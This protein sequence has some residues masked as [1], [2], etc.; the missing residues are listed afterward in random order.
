MIRDSIGQNI[1]LPDTTALR[2]L[3]RDPAFD[4]HVDPEGESL[5]SK[6]IHW[7][8]KVFEVKHGTFAENFWMEYFWYIMFAVIVAIILYLIFKNEIRG[9]FYRKSKL[10]GGTM[11][12]LDDDINAYDFDK[13][14][15]EAEANRNYRYAIRLFYLRNL[16]DLNDRG[17][18]EW[19]LEKTNAD[20]L[21]EISNRDLQRIFGRCTYIFNWIW[22]GD[23]PVNEPEYRQAAT[24]FQSFHNNIG[25][26]A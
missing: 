15:R 2:T 21:R 10:A 9:L 18:I 6:F 3:Q 19:K 4:Y 7:L 20:Y 5:W 22:Y 25:G 17:L 8:L 14:I 23:F 26:R 12:V 1:R 16:K 11:E 13:D 24:V